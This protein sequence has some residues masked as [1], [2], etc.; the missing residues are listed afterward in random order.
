M[1]IVIGGFCE[2]VNI[3]LVAWNWPWSSGSIYTIETDKFSKSVYIAPL[4]QLCLRASTSAFPAQGY[5]AGDLMPQ[6]VTIFCYLTALSVLWC[7]RHCASAQLLLWLLCCKGVV[8]CLLARWPSISF[9]TVSQ[10]TALSPSQA[11][12][13]S[14]GRRHHQQSE[15]GW[16]TTRPPA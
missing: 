14:L 5:P 15:G 12:A 8:L 9:G 13:L 4:P 10:T 1:V 6:L 7:Y 11:T 16:T 2:P 3:N